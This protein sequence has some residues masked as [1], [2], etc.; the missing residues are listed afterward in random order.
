M[1]SLE[2]LKRCS[3]AAGGAVVLMGGL[4]IAGWAGRQPV[5]KSVVPG[6]TAMNPLTA[7]AF[8]LAG[9]ALLLLQA[10]RPG[11][12]RRRLGALCAGLVAA[13]AAV[14]LAGYL[15]HGDVA[16][17]HL[18]FA[19]QLEQEPIPNRMAPNTAL[20]FLLVGSAFVLLDRQTRGHRRPA[21]TMFLAV[22]GISFTVIVGY[23]YNAISFT[24]VAY[25]P[26]A[27]N[28]ALGFLLL[29]AG[30]LA[31]RPRHGLMTLLTSPEPG[32]VIM[33]RLAPAAILIP[34]ALGFIHLLGERR[35]SLYS[36]EFGL[37]L[38]VLS[39][40]IIF[41]GLIWWSAGVVQRLNM[42]HQRADALEQK[43]LR[44]ETE[45]TKQQHEAQ[46][47]RLVEGISD[48]VAHTDA[49]GMIVFANQALAKIHGVDGA[50][51]LIGHRVVEFI[52]PEDAEQVAGVFR[53]LASSRSIPETVSAQL[54]RPDGQRVYVEVRSTAI[55]EGGQTVGTLSVIRDV[56]ERAQAEAAL[57]QEKDALQ[58][59]NQAMLGREERILELKQHINTLLK[60]LGRSPQYQNTRDGS[61]FQ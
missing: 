43:S 36:A 48:G 10:E 57:K 33:R 6:L 24:Q 4:V 27:L 61:N 46:Y 32:G 16:L 37:A 42:M 35:G 11:V 38:F 20:C 29:S 14:R 22:G 13:L 39:H 52:A 31:A 1:Q 30:G 18:L 17:D 45:M 56:T 3:R 49:D 28:T 23:I 8:Q 19:S 58:K 59:A 34:P 12:W 9:C 5:L 41:F 55:V 26:M 7:V 25:I 50:A 2:W 54:M 53:R 21:Q 44:L 47:Y 15:L 51:A 60:E 40:V